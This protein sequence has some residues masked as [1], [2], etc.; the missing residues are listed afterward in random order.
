M[1]MYIYIYVYIYIHRYRYDTP[2]YTV[3]RIVN[4]NP[5]QDEGQDLMQHRKGHAQQHGRAIASDAA[6]D[7][8]VE[9]GHTCA[10][11]WRKVINIAGTRCFQLYSVVS[12]IHTYKK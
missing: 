5:H 4:A 12:I 10:G 7:H 6:E 3:P 9:L 8:Q 2:W 11:I 1:C